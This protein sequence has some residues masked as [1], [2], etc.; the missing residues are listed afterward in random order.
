VQG[1]QSLE[2]QMAAL[3]E[4]LQD[5]DPLVD[6]PAGYTIGIPMAQ[7]LYPDDLRHLLDDGWH[8]SAPPSRSQR[9]TAELFWQVGM[10]E[11][12]ITATEVTSGPDCQ[13]VQAAGKEARLSLRGGAEGVRARLSVAPGTFVPVQ[14][15]DG[16]ARS[17][18][19]DLFVDA[20]H[21]VLVSYAQARTVVVTLP[22][23]ENITVCGASDDAA[24]TTRPGII[25]STPN[26]TGG[27]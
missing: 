5:D 27:Q 22:A 11:A 12:S 17:T 3:T 2:R 16:S 25:R 23:G 9:L 19:R 4:V 24:G 26:A 15:V 10:E 20:E 13:T 14:L 8:P 18:T 7:V 1:E 6:D 21:Q